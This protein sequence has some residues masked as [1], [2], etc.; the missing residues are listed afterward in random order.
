MIILSVFYP[1]AIDSDAIIPADEHENWGVGMSGYGE[2][3][4]S[5]V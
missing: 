5:D 2:N 3:Q 1:Y 4:N